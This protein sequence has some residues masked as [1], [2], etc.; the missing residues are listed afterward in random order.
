MTRYWSYY[1]FGMASWSQDGCT[2]D[3]INGAAQKNGYTL[4]SVLSGILHA[5]H[6]VSRVQDQ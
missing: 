1:A 4:Q 3:A 2:Q 6:F 5:P